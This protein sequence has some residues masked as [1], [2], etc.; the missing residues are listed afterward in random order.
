VSLPRDRTH[1]DGWTPLGVRRHLRRHQLTV[2]TLAAI[3][4]VSRATVFR[5]LAG[6][7]RVGS[8]R[9]RILQLATAPGA[10]YA[11]R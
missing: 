4:C 9:T 1:P 11:K 5:I 6:R 10:R 7:R 8:I 2:G 3:W